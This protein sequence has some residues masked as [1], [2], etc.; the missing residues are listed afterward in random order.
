MFTR[1]ITQVQSKKKKKNVNTNHWKTFVLRLFFLVFC[2]HLCW[3]QD[4]LN[5]MMVESAISFCYIYTAIVGNT[6]ESLYR[7]IDTVTE[8]SAVSSEPARIFTAKW[9]SSHDSH[10]LTTDRRN[11][12]LFLMCIASFF[13]YYKNWNL[14]KKFLFKFFFYTYLTLNNV[15]NI[16]F[17]YFLPF[18]GLTFLLHTD[19]I[20]KGATTNLNTKNAFIYIYYLY[21][22]IY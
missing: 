18:S 16:F 19:L 8:Y 10:A 22:C 5:T 14:L 15:L 2:E 4:Q 17:V 6:S 7:K 13:F 21:I 11:T 20:F 12:P 3:I 9:L 1:R